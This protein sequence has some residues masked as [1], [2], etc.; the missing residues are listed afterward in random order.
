MTRTPLTP[1]AI[2]AAAA[3]LADRDGFDAVVVSAVARQLGVQTASL[4]GHVRDRAAILAGIQALAMEELADQIGAEV[5]GRSRRDALVAMGDVQR[6]YARTS[7]GRWE[8]LQRRAEPGLEK[9]E[10]TIRLVTLTRAVLRGYGLSDEDLVHAARMVGAMIAGFI[11]LE[12]VGAFDHRTPDTDV[13]WHR[14][15][16]AVDA[17]LT[18]WGSGP[19]ADTH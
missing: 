1:K 4:Y 14:A 16:D 6:I 11:S 3:D 10:S 15:I 13:S 9:T 12:R 19:A 8:S 18:S 5:A 17:A 7:P 2:I